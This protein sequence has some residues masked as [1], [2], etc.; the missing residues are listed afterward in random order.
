MVWSA[1]RLVLVSE[2][3]LLDL[4]EVLRV[5]DARKRVRTV[6]AEHL[7]VRDEEGPHVSDPG[8]RVTSDDSRRSLRRRKP[9]LSGIR[10]FDDGEGTAAAVTRTLDEHRPGRRLADRD[11]PRLSAR[12]SD[13]S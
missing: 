5:S 10:A 7:D 9:P 2:A 1:V 12:R 13:A 4:V 11:P 8:G 6:R 3:E